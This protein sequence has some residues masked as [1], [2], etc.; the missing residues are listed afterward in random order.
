MSALA[1]LA[2][3]GVTMAGPLVTNAAT[4]CMTLLSFNLVY[5]CLVDCKI[6]FLKLCL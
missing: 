2:D 4:A 1:A 6:Y 5:D 3:I